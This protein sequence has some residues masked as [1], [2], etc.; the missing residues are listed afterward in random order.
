METKFLVILTYST[1]LDNISVQPYS[2]KE[3]ALA[4]ANEVIVHGNRCNYISK[5]GCGIFLYDIEND[6]KEL[7]WPEEDL[8]LPNK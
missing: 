4:Y 8:E 6:K 7:L 1:L 2:E 3:A 5:K